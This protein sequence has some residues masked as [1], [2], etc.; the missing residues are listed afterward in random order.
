MIDAACRGDKVQYLDLVLLSSTQ[1]RTRELGNYSRGQSAT[2]TKSSHCETRLEFI[3]STAEI[4][5][6]LHLGFRP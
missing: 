6:S 5:F 2:S 4:F 3:H 1:P